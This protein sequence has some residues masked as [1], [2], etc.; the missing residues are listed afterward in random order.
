MQKIPK[1]F[2]WQIE[3]FLE[4]FSKKWEKNTKNS[5]KI[6]LDFSSL[7]N[8]YSYKK[9]GFLFRKNPDFSAST[10]PV[11]FDEEKK[12]HSGLKNFSVCFQ[13]QK[14]VYFFDNHNYAL[15]SFFDFFEKIQKKITVVH[16][17]AHRDDA[18]FPYEV[19]Q[20]KS[21]EN[22]QKIISQSRI[23]EFL[24][25]GKKMGIIS[26]IFSY[27]QSREFEKFSV[28]NIPYILNLDIDI[29]GPEGDAVNT[30]LKTEVIASAWKNA[31][32]VCVATSP[33][34]IDQEFAVKLFEIFYKN[35]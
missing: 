3:S 17:D 25:A 35:L 22:L 31:D 2:F 26:E 15:R 6:F 32:M 33:A 23:S 5:E 20:E 24:D 10:E 7:K 4:N 34:F 12:G 21:E 18:I 27:T 11:F 29:F 8:S 9:S 28:P 30:Q 19:S 13:G 1:Q 16:I 14:P